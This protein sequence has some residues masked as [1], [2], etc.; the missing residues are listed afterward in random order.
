MHGFGGAEL[1]R[2][3]VEHSLG[4]M[5]VHDLEGILLAVNPAVSQSLG[6]P[7]GE[8][9]GRSLKTFL[10]PAVA[11]LFDQYLARIRTHGSDSGLMRLVARD[12][13]ERV[14]LYRNVR[15]D[16]PGAPSR[17]LGHA[18][19]ITSRMETERELK[20]ARKELTKSR[21]ELAMRVEERTAELQVANER[22]RAEI[23]RRERLEEELLRARYL[24]SLGMLAGGIAHDFN[25]FLT[26]VQGNLAMAKT[27][28]RADDP[29]VDFREETSRACQRVAALGQQLLSF[30]K[31]GAPIR[32]TVALG[33]LVAEAAE[34]ARAGSN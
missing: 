26:V 8:G 34:L 5:C 25:N 9:V 11:P 31:G 28:L 29:A 13:S 18:L 20:E 3:L 24:E 15:Y 10:A 32:R 1:N 19:D 33:R 30:A 12:G 2:L 16:E 22:L 6:Y 7:V 27:A 21:D 23:A 14:W 4:L 17:V